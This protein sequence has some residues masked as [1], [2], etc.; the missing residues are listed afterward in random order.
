WRS[1]LKS[2]PDIEDV[3]VS[4][5]R[6]LRLLLR[7]CPEVRHVIHRDLLNRNVLVAGDRLEAVFD[8][9]CSMAGDFLYEVAWFTFW[10]PWY[11][12]LAALDFRRIVR[13]HYETTGVDVPDFDERL[14]CYELYVGLE[15]LAYAAFTGREDDLRAVAARARQV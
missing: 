9:G 5:Q 15:H 6:A 4:G 10:A 8:W 14:V 11:P 7:A 12:A 1:K 3:F 2:V 13:E